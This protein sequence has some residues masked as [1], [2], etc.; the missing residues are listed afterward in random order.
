[1]VLSIKPEVVMVEDDDMLAQIIKRQLEL[2][3]MTV[4][5]FSLIHDALSF[6]QHSHTTT[7]L[8]LLDLN[9]PDG[10]GL[11]LLKELLD[12]KIDIP[13][14]FVTAVTDEKTKIQSLDMG[15]DDYLI[16]P[17]SLREMVSRI[18][19]LLRRTH[20]DSI[21]YH[22]QSNER[23]FYFCGVKV[24]PL[25][26]ELAFP[27]GAVHIGK[28]ELSIISHL[29]Q[30]PYAVLSRMALIQSIW[31]KFANARSRSLDQYIMKIRKLFQERRCPTSWLKTIHGVGYCYK[32]DKSVVASGQLKQTLAISKDTF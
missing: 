21:T 26:M 28:R 31:G 32:P 29:S 24:S 10:N 22:I 23:E 8:L 25:R 30:H 18:N 1:M 17:F 19:A 11:S 9:L 27:S 20:R 4:I 16:K 6:F 5:I 12:Q 15:G 2:I 14:I 13:T 7:H 3:D